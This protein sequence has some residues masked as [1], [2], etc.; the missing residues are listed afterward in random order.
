MI[1]ETEKTEPKKTNLLEVVAPMLGKNVEVCAKYT[2]F[3]TRDE[4]RAL[5][6]R[7]GYGTGKTYILSKYIKEYF[8]L[9]KQYTNEYGKNTIILHGDWS[10]KNKG[11]K[12]MTTPNL[13]LKRKLAKNFTVYNVDEFRTSKIC[14]VCGCNCGTFLKRESKNPKHKDKITNKYF[15]TPPNTKERMI[16]VKDNNLKWA[17]YDAFTRDLKHI[18]FLKSCALLG[19]KHLEE[20]RFDE[21]IEVKQIDRSYQRHYSDSLFQY[22]L[23]TAKESCTKR[24]C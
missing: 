19:A 22:Y 2:E 24:Y 15:G 3:I 21:Y 18:F 10:M 6:V 20:H 1:L 16:C 7:S 5:C 8:E 4:L 9:T 14:N 13:S 12:Y 23:Q 11:I 17:L